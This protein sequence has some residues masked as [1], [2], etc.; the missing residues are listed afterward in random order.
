MTENSSISTDLNSTNP[1]SDTN[2][3]YDRHRVILEPVLVKTLED[4][5]Q[6][7]VNRQCKKF[8]D[9]YEECIRRQY[10]WTLNHCRNEIDDVVRCRIK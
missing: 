8:I 7:F 10:P 3:R 2:L 1:L 4:R 5:F 9:I 6:H